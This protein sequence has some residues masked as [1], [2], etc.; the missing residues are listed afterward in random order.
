VIHKYQPA[1]TY[2]VSGKT[3]NVLEKSSRWRLYINDSLEA[4]I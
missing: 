2:F 4:D 1:F 3:E